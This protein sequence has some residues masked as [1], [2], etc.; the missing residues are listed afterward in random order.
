MKKILL[1]L[2][3]LTAGIM[4]AQIVN[5][6]DANF[7]NYLLTSPSIAV[8]GPI[9]ANNDGEIQIT[10]ALAV[11]N[12]NINQPLDVAFTSLQGIEAFKNLDYLK[13]NVEVNTI[14]VSALINLNSLDI[15]DKQLVNLNFTGLINLNT[16][17]LNTA[18]VTNL[19]FSI[20]PNLLILKVIQANGLKSLIVGSKIMSLTLSSATLTNLDLSECNG[21]KFIDF[22]FN[23][24]KDDVF[25]NLKN[26]NTT[27]EML[28]TIKSYH[29]A[30]DKN[31]CYVCIDEGEE[32]SFEHLADNIILNTYCS[33]SPGGTF[34]TIAG[35]VTFDADN[36][37]CNVA[38]PIFPLMKVISN[39]GFKEITTF[40]NTVGDY[41][42]YPQAG[43]FTIKP[44]F[45]NE[46]FATTPAVVVFSD[47][48]NNV[49]TQNFCITANGVHND[50]EVV[51]VPISA[52][53]PG[54]DADYK[55]IYKNKGNQ[56]LSGNI[57]FTYN[58][59]VLD[60]TLSSV[61]ASS[62]ASGSLVWDYTNLQP[63]ESR[64][65]YVQFNV[66]GS[67]E[68]PA[69]NFDDV[70]AF[71]AVITPFEND[72]TPADNTFVYNQVVVGSFDPNNITC[73]EGDIVNPS[74]IGEYLHYNINF[75]N[76]GTAPAKFIVVKNV[77]DATQFDIN[78]FQILNASHAMQ[79]RVTG[80]KVE[81]IFDDINLAGSG[82]GNVSFKIKSLTT[83]PVNSKVTQN[84]NIY[85]DYNFPVATNN[86]ETVF[87]I[88]STGNFTIDNSVSIYPNPSNGV[89]NIKANTTI[90]SLQ[91]YDVQGRLLQAGKGD[92]I[93]ISGRA[94][95]LY[96]LKIQTEKGTKVE[97]VV[98]K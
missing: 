91:L 70:L 55:I 33:F 34:N 29:Q 35:K 45:E 64:E 24:N 2:F 60:Y 95:G 16:L 3:L 63:F 89:V 20:L 15:F 31:K 54:F 1:C 32:L 84:A 92:N 4:N 37:G 96:F 83:V 93:D 68:I 82:K 94:T 41:R 88:L 40:T 10:E 43:S 36:N 61:E 11:L 28:G 53:R 56:I 85:F 74:M 13:L 71:T 52:A 19:D 25:V 58:D 75:E 8:P 49:T 23:N 21:L 76:T 26:G 80:N 51:I 67:T 97:R 27:Y 57:T 12:L 17:T 81:F 48:N 66:N 69:V 14:D 30:E 87:G 5:I 77:I 98:K 18:P 44:K 9:D 86:A 59:D 47:N 46:W 73:L 6:P 79:T 7:K 42:L 62:P 22:I 72:E 50:T 38:D 90:T 78:S 65:I 39:D